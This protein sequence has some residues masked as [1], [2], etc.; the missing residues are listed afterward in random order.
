MPRLTGFGGVDYVFTS[1]EAGNQVGGS[2]A[3]GGQ[4]EALVNMYVGLRAK[5]TEQLTGDCTINYTDSGSDFEGRDY[6]RL[7][8]SAG[9]SYSF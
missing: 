8:L 3:A 4:E 9:V 7:R 2:L 5:L 1:F 6:D